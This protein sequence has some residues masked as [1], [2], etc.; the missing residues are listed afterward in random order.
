MRL[1]DK[2]AL[3]T[4]ASGGIGAALAQGLA[5]EGAHIVVNW[6]RNKAG[7][8]HTANMIRSLKQEALTVQADVGDPD[9][10]TAMFDAIQNWKGHLDIVINNAGITLKKPFLDSDSHDWDTIHNANL[11]SVFLCSQKAVALMPSGGAILNISSTH[12]LSTTYNFSVYAASKGG[13]EALTRSMAIELGERHIRVNALRLGL[14]NVARDAIMPAH[15]D[16]AA[17]CARIP[18]GRPGDVADVVPMAILL[19]SDEAAYITGQIIVIDGGCEPMLNTAFPK[20]HIK[21][22]AHN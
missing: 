1:K 17:I 9:A 22:G 5:A 18:L 12:A 2:I 16:Y 20:G 13:L 8:E 4:G 7:A 15:P 21:D 3:I 6:R 11:K 10:V 14:I 19:C